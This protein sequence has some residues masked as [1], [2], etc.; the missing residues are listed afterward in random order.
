MKAVILVG[1]QGTRLR[2]LTCTIPKPMLPLVNIP[3]L[4]HVIRLLK[5]FDI[6]DIILSTSYRP[7]CFES[8]FADGCHLKVKLTYVTEEKPLGTCGAVKNVERFLEGTFIVFNGDIVT[9]LNLAQLMEY[10]HAKKAVATIALTPVEDPTAYGLV[11]LDTS[12]QVLNFVE[13]PSWDEV[14]TDLINAGTYVLEPE[15]LRYAPKGENYSFERDFFPI[16][17]E[18]GE[19]VFGFPSGAYWLDIGTPEKYLQAHHDIL[20][21]KLDFEF[22]GREIKPRVW[23]GEGTE[24]GP[25]ATIFG[26]TVIGKNCRIHSNATIFSNTTI[27]NNCV[28]QTGAMLERCVIFDGCHIDEASVV[29]NSLLGRGLCLGKKVHVAE[30]A[31]LG[32]NMIIEDENHLKRGVR[33]WPDTK[34]ERAKIKF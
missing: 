15:I 8:Y 18:K 19:R 25:E 13:K 29:R 1:G 21:G 26:P 6:T 12:G 31:V 28:I 7:E 32:D 2:P 22:S 14:T 34:I 11:P 20:D 27:G 33:I 16:L 17:L 10:H 5:Q 4:E 24:I 3:L 9:N 23:I 30:T